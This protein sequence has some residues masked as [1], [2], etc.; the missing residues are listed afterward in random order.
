MRFFVDLFT[1]WL[2]IRFCKL[3]IMRLLFF[4]CTIICAIDGEG[5]WGQTVQTEAF[6]GEGWVK[7]EGSHTSIVH[8]WGKLSAKTGSGRIGD[9]KAA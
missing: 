8:G 2:L 5:G 3:L 4:D 7:A 1:D 9:R 6:G